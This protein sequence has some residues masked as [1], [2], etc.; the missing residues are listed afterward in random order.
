[1]SKLI[2]EG[3]QLELDILR[4]NTVQFYVKIFSHGIQGLVTEDGAC[5]FLRVF[6]SMYPCTLSPHIDWA[7]ALIVLRECLKQSRQE[8]ITAQTASLKENRWD[9]LKGLLEALAARPEA[10]RYHMSLADV[11]LLPEV[12]AVALD[13]QIGEE[14]VQALHAQFG[15]A[16]EKWKTRACEK[17]RDLVRAGL[18]DGPILDELEHEVDPLE[19]ATTKFRCRCVGPYDDALFYPAVLSHRCQQD[20]EPRPAAEPTSDAYETFVLEQLGDTEEGRAWTLNDLVVDE[21]TQL[22]RK[23]FDLCGKNPDLTTAAEMDEADVWF[24]LRYANFVMTWRTAVS[25]VCLR[26]R[27]VWYE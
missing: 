27:L 24:V 13:T 2:A 9:T 19:L 16:V 7:Q 4:Q 5:L 17:L 20:V 1:M 6:P 26:P 8:R 22:S 25:A 3:Y 10:R 18:V 14:N 15:E 12:R 23:L 11:A 21:T